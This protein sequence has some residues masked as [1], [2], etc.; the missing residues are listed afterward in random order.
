MAAPR[1]QATFIRKLRAPVSESAIASWYAEAD[2]L[3]S[4]AVTIDRQITTSVHELVVQTLASHPTWLQAL[5]HLRDALVRPFG[6]MTTKVMKDAAQPHE[7]IDFFR[8][9]SETPDEI[10]LGDDDR[11]LNFRVSFLKRTG[12]N[13]TEVIATTVVHINNG[14]G[15]FYIFLIAPFHRLVVR[16]SLKRLAQ[17]L[18]GEHDPICPALGIPIP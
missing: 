17:T 6:V 8:I 2:L 12:P 1:N 14:F 5:F 11:H 9:Q 4:Y 7:R 16:T 15:R 13:G 18:A 3:D 10:I